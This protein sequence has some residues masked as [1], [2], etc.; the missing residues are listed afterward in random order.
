MATLPP[1]LNSAGL[2][3]FPLIAH[4]VVLGALWVGREDPFNEVESCLID[5]IADM[6]ASAIATTSLAHGLQNRNACGR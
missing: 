1:E 4:N 3:G 2:H 5:G 6:A